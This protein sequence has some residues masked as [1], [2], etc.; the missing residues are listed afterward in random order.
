MFTLSHYQPCIDRAS[1]VLRT[2][3]TEHLATTQAA[4]NQAIGKRQYYEAILQLSILDD[5][6]FGIKSTISQDNIYFRKLRGNA[7]KRMPMGDLRYRFAMMGLNLT[8]TAE[9]ILSIYH[10]KTSATFHQ[11]IQKFIDNL[12]E[13]T[14]PDKY[15]IHLGHFNTNYIELLL[16]RHLKVRREKATSLIKKARYF[17]PIDYAPLTVINAFQI[18]DQSYYHIDRP[19]TALTKPQ[20]L[21]YQN[22][23][24][25]NW[26]TGES[27]FCQK[28]IE[29]AIPYV[30]AGH[31]LPAQ[32][33]TKMP[34]IRNC[35]HELL[36][37]TSDPN[38]IL[39]AFHSGTLAQNL[40]QVDNVY[41][42]T[43][44]LRQVHHNLQASKYHLS[45]LLTPIRFLPDDTMYTNLLQKA[46]KQLKMA[47]SPDTA[48]VYS[49]PSINISRHFFIKQKF[50]HREQS[51]FFQGV[52]ILI[53]DAKD[54]LETTSAAIDQRDVRRLT[55]LVNRLSDE[56]NAITIF[57]CDNNNM[58][59]A[60]DTRLLCTY[61]NRVL[62]DPRH[63]IQLDA[64]K[65]GKERCG[66]TRIQSIIHALE[67]DNP[68][69][70]SHDTTV[71]TVI[72]MRIAQ[73]S[74][75]LH[76]NNLGSDGLKLTSYRSAPQSIRQYGKHIFMPHSTL[77]K[78]Y[79][80]L[81]L[82][83]KQQLLYIAA[84]LVSLPLAFTGVGIYITF[85]VIRRLANIDAIKRQIHYEQPRLSNQVM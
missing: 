15:K 20:Q 34:G 12:L 5:D 54:V 35:G 26:F 83:M 27:K 58:K 61:L 46:M 43:E 71:R 19:V 69:N 31:L 63:Y 79:P 78:R 33:K 53:E 30:L 65:N 39:S 57:D 72:A 7:A 70:N 16:M 60:A 82:T 40:K 74:A 80:S 77:N 59:I 73:K 24:S 66:L 56:L 44:N 76:G 4:L 45:N 37:N 67:L 64:C 41:Y 47:P 62:N 32:V 48:F 28:L 49:N 68:Q 1:R 10:I 21:I 13:E 55:T 8:L 85:L 14:D 17:V 36:F 11:Q 38:P 81:Q 9:K 51:E 25:Q 23:A 3:R 42:T 84:L 22:Y 50:G 6:A 52:R 2:V 75:G 29:Q 18:N